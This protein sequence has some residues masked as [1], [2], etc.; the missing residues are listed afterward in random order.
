M[1]GSKFKPEARVFVKICGITNEPDA[2][3]AIEAGADALGFN[4]VRQSKRYI[5]IDAAEAWISNLPRE[6][7]KVVVTA[8]PIFEDALWLA[9][10]PFVDALQLHGSESPEFCRDLAAAG[11]AFGK[12][13]PVVDANSLK[14][15]PD[16][17]TDTLIL[18]TASGCEIGGT[19]KTFPW[20][21]AREFAQKNPNFQVILAGGLNPE[22]VAGAIEQSRPFGVD[23]TTGVEASPGRK[24]ARLVKAFI[25]AVWEACGVAG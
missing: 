25:K 3:V 20:R 21:L 2:L 10:L 18:D 1:F 23:V 17:S 11:L 5:D 22:N 19:G 13:L 12:A 14:D 4:L 9:K 6:I 15:V 7:C 16:F 8:N 24:D